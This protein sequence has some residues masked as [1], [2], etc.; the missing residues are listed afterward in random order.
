MNR[1]RNSMDIAASILRLAARGAKKTHLVYKANLNF[2]FL[3]EY[4]ERLEEA[5]LMEGLAPTQKGIDFLRQ[6]DRL[7]AFGF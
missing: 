6:Y 3:E 7:K 1:R 2:V 4:L 5:G